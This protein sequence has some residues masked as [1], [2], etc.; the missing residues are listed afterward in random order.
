MRQDIWGNCRKR[1][2][3]TYC[4]TIYIPLAQSS[5][6]C[7]LPDLWYIQQVRIIENTTVAFLNLT[8][9]IA[10]G[11]HDLSI[12]TS[13]C[14]YVWRLLIYHKLACYEQSTGWLAVG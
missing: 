7:L 5:R 4:P 2:K 13:V 14:K 3:R 12:S 10:T 9:E 6:G 11:Q 8:K 1:Q